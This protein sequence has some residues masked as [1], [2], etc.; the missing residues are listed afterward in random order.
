MSH[1][2]TGNQNK[3]TWSNY[4][5]ENGC[6]QEMADFTTNPNNHAQ[7]ACNCGYWHY[8]KY[9]CTEKRWNA[10]R[11][12]VLGQRHPQCKIGCHPYTNYFNEC[13]GEPDDLTPSFPGY[14]RNARYVGRIK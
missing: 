4:C 9:G 8:D 1:Y 11:Y 6:G 5:S 3:K 12:W 13:V 7:T 14:K 10:N 2:S